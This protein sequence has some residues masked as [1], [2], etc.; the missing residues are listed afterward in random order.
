MT[1][2]TGVDLLHIAR[3]DDAIKRHGERFLKRVYTAAELAYC[4]GRLPEL[5]ARFAAKEAASKAL[6]VGVRILSPNGI[7]WHDAEVGRTEAGKPILLLHGHAAQLARELGVR[8]WS[9]SLSHER[10]T[11]IAFVVGI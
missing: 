1:L 3:I 6:G 8:S 11:A 7:A 4:A 2:T 10:D 5:A 9:I